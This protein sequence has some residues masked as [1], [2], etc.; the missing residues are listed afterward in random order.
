MIKDISFIKGV[1]MS[2]LVIT[3]STFN[4][5][6]SA[7]EPSTSGSFNF[8]YIILIFLMIMITLSILSYYKKLQREKGK[9][10]LSSTELVVYNSSSHFQEDNRN[11]QKQNI[12]NK[13]YFNVYVKQPYSK[14]SKQN[15]YNKKSN[16][17][18]Q[19]DINNATDDIIDAEMVL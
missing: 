8:I 5:I 18:Y 19:R 16:F 6:K 11:N 4:L 7:G 15:N 9:K 17:K 12:Y 14:N 1:T 2:E 10:N 13:Y 3:E